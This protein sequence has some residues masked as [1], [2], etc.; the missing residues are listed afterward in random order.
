MNEEL[1]NKALEELINGFI[2]TKD[3]ILEQTPD[4]I[5]QLLTFS[6][7]EYATW[8]TFALLATIFLSILLVKFA[9]KAREFRKKNEAEF[10]P[11]SMHAIFCFIGRGNKH[12]NKHVNNQRQLKFRAWDKL[13][14]RF[15]YPD[16]GYQG[17]YVLSLKGEFQNL[18][19]GSGFGDYVVQ[20]FTGLKD[21]NGKE[22]YEGDIVTI[23]PGEKNIR[24]EL[25]D[26][27]FENV[28][29]AE[30]QPGARNPEGRV[31]RGVYNQSTGEYIAP[32]Y[33]D[34]SEG[35]LSQFTYFLGVIPFSRLKVI[36][37][38]I[39]VVGNIFENPELLKND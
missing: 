11:L 19:N 4:V 13:E 7:F 22:V 23:N 17:H 18:Q 21:K 33:E 36:N 26:F 16:K 24:R 6:L 2:S 20:Q 31:I 29:L 5:N 15:I 32:V 35:V 27:F 28:L 30:A 8:T 3:F 34:F 9:Q 14:K 37:H 1:I 38:S 25:G 12:F 10:I 39:V